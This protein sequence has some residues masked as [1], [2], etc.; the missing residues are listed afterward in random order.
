M[1]GA[2]TLFLVLQS[3][4]PNLYISIIT[5]ALSDSGF[6]DIRFIIANRTTGQKNLYPIVFQ[7]IKTTF[8]S[9]YKSLLPQNSGYQKTEALLRLEPK[10]IEIDF[11]RPHDKID[12]L[13]R[14]MKQGDFVDV[15]GTGKD[16]FVELSA[17]LAVKGILRIG[18]FDTNGV[19]A[20]YHH[21]PKGRNYFTSFENSATLTALHRISRFE[22]RRTIT[23][24]SIMSI[25]LVIATAILVVV[26][27][28]N[29]Q[30][31]TTIIAFAT[32]IVTLIDKFIK[33]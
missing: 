13:A 29:Y 27:D 5:H 1:A 32:A 17:A 30:L 7:N 9:E 20:Q 24:L 16:L 19:K 15:T 11:A 23:V 22:R 14:L 28:Q 31:L 18:Y 10:F 33:R 26:G 8:D 6:D 25:L 4:N 21:L 3:D 2:K 12:E